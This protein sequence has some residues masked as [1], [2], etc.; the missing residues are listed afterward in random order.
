MKSI[1][2]FPLVY[3]IPFT[4][5]VNMKLEIIACYRITIERIREEADHLLFVFQSRM[6]LGSISSRNASD[7]DLNQMWDS[8]ERENNERMEQKGNEIDTKS[9]I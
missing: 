7:E 3:F 4:F 5:E 1:P 6:E 2:F 9:T 8:G